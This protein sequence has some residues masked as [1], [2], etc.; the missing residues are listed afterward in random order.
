M[1]YYMIIIDV[2]FIKL[3]SHVSLFISCHTSGISKGSET[4]DITSNTNV[5]VIKTIKSDSSSWKTLGLS[6]QSQKITTLSISN[7]KK[8]Q[9]PGNPVNGHSIKMGISQSFIEGE[10]VL[11]S[12]QHTMTTSLKICLNPDSLFTTSPSNW[13]AL[14]AQATAL[15][16]FGRATRSLQG[17]KRFQN[18]S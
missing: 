4:H 14:K 6:S 13:A 8:S 2:N 10:E 9:Q 7:Q 12:T 1:S 11:D 17:D 16:L 18:C 3:I 5:I 15:P